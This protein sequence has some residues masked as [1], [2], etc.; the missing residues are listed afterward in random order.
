LRATTSQYATT[1]RDRRPHSFV[2]DG[3]IVALC[4]RKEYAVEF[5][6]SMEATT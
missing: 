4:I 2:S 1:R 5:G 6:G 3:A